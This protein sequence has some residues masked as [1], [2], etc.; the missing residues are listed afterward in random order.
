MGLF[1]SLFGNDKTVITSKIFFDDLRTHGKIS[2]SPGYDIESS[3]HLLV[4]FQIAK[5][6]YVIPN[7]YVHTKD[8]IKTYFDVCDESDISDKN[9][10]KK[11]LQN[12][13]EGRL[14][15]RYVF[16][17]LQNAIETFES[18][19]VV[20]SNKDFNFSTKIPLIGGRT[21]AALSTPLVILALI[22]ESEN[23]ELLIKI[24]RSVRLMCGKY[25]NG[26]DWSAISNC[27]DLPLEIFD[28]SK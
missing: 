4:L 25:I 8:F 2:V 18:E 6:L 14:H 13:Y 21:D 15:A 16:I 27:R 5:V 26:L 22:Q 23:T 9:R 3:L 12:T 28:M 17:P 24:Q 11:A 7:N 10:F 1:S 20:T 19:L